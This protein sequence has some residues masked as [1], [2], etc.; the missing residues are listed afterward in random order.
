MQMSGQE[1]LSVC[2]AL[3]AGGPDSIPSTTGFLKHLWKCR[4]S[5]ARC[6]TKKQTQTKNN[7]GSHPG[8]IESKVLNLL[9][10]SSEDPFYATVS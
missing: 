5:T 4:S 10:G 8:S 3:R 1:R 9:W 2:F 6:A 7:L